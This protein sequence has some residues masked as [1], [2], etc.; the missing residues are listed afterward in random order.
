[1]EK[2]WWKEAVVYQIYPRSFNDSNGDGIGDLR[3]IIEKIDYLEQLGVDAVW[4]NPIYKSPNDDNGYDI[5][6]Y[7]AIMDEFGTME[8]LEELMSLLKA[9]DMKIIMD[10]VI[11]HTSDEHYWFKESAK[12]KDNPYSDYYVWKDGKNAS[13]PNNWKSFFGGSVWEYDK[14][15]DQYYLHLFSKKQPD[16]NWENK[17]VREELYEMIN[18]WLEKGIDGFRLDVINLISKNQD[19]PDGK[20]GGL[21]GHEHFANGP[22]VHEF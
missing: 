11:N 8:D 6:D 15:T 22:R 18:W 14:K 4:L 13:P 7:R 19:F 20:E 5:S 1:M 12:S 2:Q 3:G 10:L 16:L 9:R 17:K 21:C